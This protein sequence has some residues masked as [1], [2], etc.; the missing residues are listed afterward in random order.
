MFDKGEGNQNFY[1]AKPDVRAE[2]P[3]FFSGRDSF[4]E[5]KRII[6][7]HRQAGDLDEFLG[8]YDAA[9][10]RMKSKTGAFL[11]EEFQK[12]FDKLD[13]LLS[14]ELSQYMKNISGATVSEKEA[15]R[16]QRQIPNLDMSETQFDEAIDAYETALKNAQRYFV[17]HYGFADEAAA[18]KTILGQSGTAPDAGQ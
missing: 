12:D 3:S 9:Q 5:A 13:N 1:E 14:K 11:D 2:F 7:K 18:R 4:A 6:E 10:Q 16:L 8:G 15:E 17:N